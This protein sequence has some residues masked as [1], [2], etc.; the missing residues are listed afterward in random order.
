MDKFLQ[1]LKDNL[2][3]RPELSPTPGAWDKMSKKIQQDSKSRPVLIPWWW[4]PACI[5][6]LLA[7]QIYLGW[8][9]VEKGQPVATS[10]KIIR[11]TVF[12]TNTVF[13]IDTIV[14]KKTVV[15]YV[16]LTDTP[17][18]LDNS[19]PRERM[20]QLVTELGDLFEIPKETPSYLITAGI[21]LDPAPKKWSSAPLPL[22]TIGK[23]E[24]TNDEKTSISESDRP[25]VVV[26]P[27]SF[28]ILKTSINVIETSPLAFYEA[29]GF[30]SA[31]TH[32]KRKKIGQFFSEMITEITPQG[33][34][35]GMNVSS[36]LPLEGNLDN[37][38]GYAG[39]ISAS[40]DFSDNFRMVADFSYNALS[41]TS[42][43][44]SALFGFPETPQVAS[45]FDF[46]KAVAEQELLELNVGF[47]YLLLP[48]APKF[49][50]FLG[51]GY[52]MVAI[53]PYEVEYGFEDLNTN[54]ELSVPVLVS[55]PAPI[56]DLGIITAGIE[57][58]LNNSIHLQ[59]EMLYRQR[60][61]RKGILTPNV[62]G[63][64]FKTYYSF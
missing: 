22:Y 32:R 42:D 43:E 38:Y 5:L 60:L 19:F 46:D 57:V 37:T 18:S 7:L 59:T 8:T 13:S 4:L 62:L 51:L 6:P 33:Y 1:N 58:Q 3:N 61:G 24:D 12:Q 16:Q 44:P 40:A 15:K 36:V 50:P 11:D 20:E 28:S 10:V 55:K 14:E 23:V 47:Q 63:F 29:N 39:G 54:V 26:P 17:K 21:G 30:E 52:S 48:N 56:T 49:R 9:P 31:D 35:L 41:L 53:Q 25:S 2:D 34:N 45:N 27:L 64:R